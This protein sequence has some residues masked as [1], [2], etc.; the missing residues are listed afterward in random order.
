MDR[1]IVALQPKKLNSIMSL[2]ETALCSI[3]HHSW[4]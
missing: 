4:A 1:E 3:V 2:S